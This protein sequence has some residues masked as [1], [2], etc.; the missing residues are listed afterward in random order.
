M[1]GNYDDVI[2]VASSKVAEAFLQR[3]STLEDRARCL[4]ADIKEILRLVGL[5]AV[6]QI[7][8]ELGQRV[9]G[10]AEES[11]LVVNRR[12]TSKFSVVFGAVEVPSPYLWDPV[13]RRSAR[14]VR[15]RLGIECR[16][17]S[18]TVVRALTDFG[19]EESFGQSAKRF[20]EH[21]GWEVGRT[22]IL[23]VVEGVAVEAEEYV[24]HR[25]QESRK[26]FD[27][28]LAARPGCEQLLVELDGCEIRTGV[29]K[30]RPGRERTPVRRHKRRRRHQEWRDVRVGLARRLDE[31]D[32][33]AVARLA[34][35]EEVTEQLFC[36]A[37]GRGLSSRTKTVAVAD[38][39]NGLRDALAERF[40][41]MQFIL[42]QPHLKGHLYETAEALGYGGQQREHWV[43]GHMDKIDVG[44]A[45]E[46]LTDLRTEYRRRRKHR[47]RRLIGYVKRFGDAMHYAHY[48]AQGL[49]TGSGE[50]ESAHRTIPQKRLKISGATWHPKTINP[51]L[52][53]RVVRANDWWE[54]F[55]QNRAKRPAA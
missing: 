13:S 47:L 26:A 54:D 7:L 14:P 39:G 43:S 44:G 49:P 22:S 25:L 17:R 11:G 50:V 18:E 40:T 3:E 10:A 53:L 31:V 29:L 8:E 55:C 52:A 46:A 4:D 30:P 38:G 35:Y 37:V 42:D 23:R 20:K 12:L 21:Y 51:M 15:E 1:D 5:G 16:G 34:P 24:E 41:P 45:N 19:A 28:P 9:V 48:R 2:A 6:R 36:A 32:R 33:T 27:T